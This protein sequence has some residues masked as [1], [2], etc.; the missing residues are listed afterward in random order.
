MRLHTYSNNYG[1]IRHLNG[2]GG[3]SETDLATRIQFIQ[4]RPID[5]IP[6]PNM[7]ILRAAARR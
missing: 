5:H 2:M 7:F 1:C 3:K 4:H 6:E